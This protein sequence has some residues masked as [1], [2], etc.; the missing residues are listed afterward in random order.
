VFW[1]RSGFTLV[2]LLIVMTILVIFAVIL[3]G[4]IK[5]NVLVGRANDSKRKT[6]LNKIRTAFEEFFNDKGR[7]PTTAEINIWNQLSNCDKTIPDLKNYLNV[8][9][10]DPD[11]KIYRIVVGANWFKVATNLEYKQ[12]KDI[13]VDW[14]KSGTYIG[15]GFSKSDVNYGV[16]S[17]NILWYSSI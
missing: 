8:W 10:C 11:K 5:P 9:P 3:I 7:Y 15:S 6:D 17:S 4:I 13:P 14:Y 12:D 1:N 2:E 16:S